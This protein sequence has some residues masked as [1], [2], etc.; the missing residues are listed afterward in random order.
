MVKSYASLIFIIQ[1]KSVLF[2]LFIYTL[3]PR[4]LKKTGESQRGSIEKR[5]QGKKL[6]GKHCNRQYKLLT[7]HNIYIALF[8]CTLVTKN[9]EYYS[10]RLQPYI[11]YGYMHDKNIC[12][13]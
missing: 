10:Y 1:A 7:D 13:F 9:L 5:G 2:C 6:F 11:S 8:R 4:I 3:G 12:N